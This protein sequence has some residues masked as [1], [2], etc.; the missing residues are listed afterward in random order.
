MN[1]SRPL[2]RTPEQMTVK[3]AY[4]LA[5][6]KLEFGDEPVENTIHQAART[7]TETAVGAGLELNDAL[8]YLLSRWKSETK[9]GVVDLDGNATCLLVAFQRIHNKGM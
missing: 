7:L 1:E 3:I 5:K 6:L 9:D 2:K 4:E 8:L